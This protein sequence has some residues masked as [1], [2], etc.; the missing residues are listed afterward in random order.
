[1]P[2][3]QNWPAD[4]VERRLVSDLLPHARN[5][6]VHSPAQIKQI[7]RSIREFGWT[8]PVLVDDDG[9]LIAGHGRVLA[10]GTLKITEVPVMV[11]EGWSD[12]QKRAY[13]I[14]DNRLTEN[15]D[16]DDDML[17]AEL[18]YL[19][20]NDFDLTLT[21]VSDDDLTTLLDAVDFDPQPGGDGVRLDVVD[22][23]PVEC[24]NCGHR[25]NPHG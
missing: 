22:G 7:A 21:A 8:I 11:A 6:R 10:A 2:A 1:M 5:A 15:A 4:K 9:V 20:D 24:P 18:Q 12:A 23:N 25:F 19:K 14:A 16:W 17:A 3:A 13:M